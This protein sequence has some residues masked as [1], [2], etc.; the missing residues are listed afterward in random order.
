[1]ENAGHRRYPRARPDLTFRP[2]GGHFA[3]TDRAGT[4]A[5]MLN[6]TAALVWTYCDGRHDPDAIAKAVASDLP[7]AGDTRV[8]EARVVALLAQFARQGILTER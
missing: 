1:V 7:D 4:A 8:V 3:L 5:E 2:V 6:L